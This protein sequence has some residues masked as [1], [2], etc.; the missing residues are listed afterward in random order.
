MGISALFVHLFPDNLEQMSIWG[1]DFIDL[2]PWWR[3]AWG[4]GRAESGFIWEKYVLSQSIKHCAKHINQSQVAF[5][6]SLISRLFCLRLHKQTAKKQEKKQRSST[7]PLPYCISVFISYY[8]TAFQKNYYNILQL[9][10]IQSLGL[11]VRL[12]L[13]ITLFIIESNS[14][15]LWQDQLIKDWWSRS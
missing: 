1:R 12:V 11:A 9:M 8:C 5:S 2:E 7:A 10:I 13:L 15:F 4:M 3:E 14:N 6:L